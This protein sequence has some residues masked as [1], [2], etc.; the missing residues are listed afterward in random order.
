MFLRDA[1]NLCDR[2]LPC[3][4]RLGLFRV[5]VFYY[6]NLIDFTDGLEY[7][8]HYFDIDKLRGP[9][10]RNSRNFRCFLL[11]RRLSVRKMHLD[12]VSYTSLVRWGQ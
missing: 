8:T 3:R 6:E 11:V 2:C 4:N 7:G 12:T 1:G 9:A 10:Q 5:A